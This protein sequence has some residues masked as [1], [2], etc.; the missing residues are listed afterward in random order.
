L[1]RHAFAALTA[2]A[3]VGCG[4]VAGPLPPLAN[5]PAPITDLGAIQR[6]A[7][8]IVHFSPPA[9]T[10]ENVPIGTP[11]ELDL[12]IGPA[13]AGERWEAEA[14]KIPPV[15]PAN[16][17]AEYD[18]PAAEWV[19]KTIRIEA[20]SAGENGKYSAWSNIVTF[21]VM[22]PLDQP[23][24]LHS[25]TTPAGLKLAWQARGTH[26]RVLRAAGAEPSYAVV[27]TATQPEWT[28]PGAAVGTNYRYLVQTF[29]PLSGNHEAQS[30]LS[31]P[32]T[33]T[34]EPLPPAAP[35]GLRAVAG[36]NSIELSWDGNAE[37]GI[38]GYRIYRGTPGGPLERIG[39]AG[40]IPTYSDRAVEH[41]R[42]YSYA[43]TAVGASGR[44]SPKS[45]LVD[46]PLP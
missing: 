15:K 12:R 2:A 29:D 5:I 32:Y 34:P 3:C 38:T 13:D 20:R 33:V 6:G 39:E 24:N 10:T 42:N 21:P 16:G 43:V 25:E 36:P 31:E 30:E 4:Y 23:V 28:D 44:E 18:V 7:R 37:S 19:G 35:A 14:K 46:L 40:V 17:L 45:S 1:T 26:F 8:L 11:L 27:A 41:G 9:D 22:P